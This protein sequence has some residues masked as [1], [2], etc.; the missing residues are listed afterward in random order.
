MPMRHLRLCGMQCSCADYTTAAHPE[1]VVE[2]QHGED[3]RDT[4]QLTS[5]VLPA[6]SPRLLVNQAMRIWGT[7]EAGCRCMLERKHDHDC[8]LP[9][10][11]HSDRLT[12]LVVASD[13]A[14]AAA[15]AAAQ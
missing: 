14:V 7:A 12:T 13:G 3:V 11:R 9:L 8:A 2:Q 4:P 15:T 5:S 6:V 1:Q 10:V